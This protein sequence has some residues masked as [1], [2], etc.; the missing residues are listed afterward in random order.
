MRVL[1]KIR[2]STLLIIFSLIIVIFIIPN[3]SADPYT[4]TL[5]SISPS[6]QSVDTDESFTVDVYCVPGQPIKAFELR[7]SF[8]ESLLRADSVVEGD[9]FNNYSTFFNSGTINNNDGS[10]VDIYSLILGPGNVTDPG[11]FVSIN[12]TAKAK[13]GTSVLGFL[14]VGTWTG[15]TNETSYVPISVS[16]GSV[17]VNGGGSPPPPPPGG[18]GGFPPPPPGDDENNPPMM[19]LQPSGPTFV[20]LGVE[21]SF[22]SSTIDKDGDQVRYRF[23][24]GD[25]NFS[26]W[27]DL[28]DSNT[29]INMSY[30]WSS[31]SV[32]KVS[33][34]AQDIKGLNSSWSPA[35]NVTVSQ[36]DLGLPPVIEINFTGNILVNETIVF[37]GSGCY[38]PD[39]LIISYLWDFGDGWISND[40]NPVHVYKKPG[41]YTV[42]LTVTDNNNNTASKSIILN[43][44]YE[45]SEKDSEELGIVLPIN[46]NFIIF[47]IAIISIVCIVLVFRKKIE[48]YSL[49]HTNRKI[50]KLKK[51]L[52]K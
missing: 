19:P 22:S 6:S 3:V 30:S 40:I 34:V 21:Y 50:K 23:D 31:I 49:N 48:L 13:A 26:N 32:Y 11:T 41:D 8:D 52:H 20:E 42:T 47:V 33:V 9:I 10:I 46:F 5:L 1:K 7:L 16:S 2:L 18:G 17:V 25:G 44:N 35:L 24:W 37:D 51:K 14:D 36:T 15:V 27:S 29:S 4:D 12:F 38:D 39:G 28:V 43:I 45:G